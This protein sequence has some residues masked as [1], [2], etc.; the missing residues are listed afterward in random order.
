MTCSCEMSGANVLSPDTIRISS[1]FGVEIVV[2][3]GIL[4]INNVRITG[5][6]TKGPSARAVTPRGIDIVQID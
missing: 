3:Q 5:I 2:A 4:R 1:L 6:V